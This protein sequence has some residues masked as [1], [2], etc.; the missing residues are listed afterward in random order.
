VQH[1]YET[2]MW[3][4]TADLAEFVSGLDEAQWDSPSLCEGWRVRDVIGHMCVGHTKSMGFILSGLA[5][6]RFDLDAASKKA[7]IEFADEHTG[8]ELAGIL[9]GVAENRTLKGI[10]RLIPKKA[11]LTDHL[12]HHQ[13][14]RRP[15]G[16]PRTI[17]EE[18]L[19]A[20]LD[21]LPQNLGGAMPARKRIKGLRLVATDVD[22]SHGEGPELRGPAEA[23]ILASLGR[24]AALAELEGAGSAALQAAVG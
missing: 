13:D 17:P 5:R 15:L 16:L 7:S 24:S 1:D 12:V 9:G 18:R 19:R 11:G 23:L 21:A 3:E 8:P 10:S 20:A 22:W 2:L 4:E 6:S 14:I